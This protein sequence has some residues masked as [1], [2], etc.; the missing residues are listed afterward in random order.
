MQTIAGGSKEGYDLVRSVRMAGY[1]LI[2]VGP[3]LHFWFNFVSRVFP[4]RDLFSTFAKMALGQAVYGPI[5]T[6]LFFSV[7]AALQ[8]TTISTK[9]RV[10]S[11]LRFCSSF[12][13]YIFECKKP[14]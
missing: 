12:N 14:H 2:I 1:G 6:A 4:K 8:G 9:S 13:K 11:L 3:S 10:S 5:A 7:N